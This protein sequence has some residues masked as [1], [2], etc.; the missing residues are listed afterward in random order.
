MHYTCVG[1]GPCFDLP[2]VVYQI[3]SNRVV[4]IY[5]YKTVHFLVNLLL[6]EADLWEWY[7]TRKGFSLSSVKAIK[8]L[9]GH[10]LNL[11]KDAR[12][13][14]FNVEKPERFV[15]L[16]LRVVISGLWQSPQAL[17]CVIELATLVTI[18]WKWTRVTQQ[19]LTRLMSCLIYRRLYACANLLQ[20]RLYL[21]TGL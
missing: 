6:T 1:G 9:R 13:N 12:G 5:C 17:G 19:L 11:L 3:E 2:T 4:F 16:C 20:S 14:L 10:V 8:A 15:K 18:Y 7:C 21:Q